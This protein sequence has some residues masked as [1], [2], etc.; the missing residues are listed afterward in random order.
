[1]T[2]K[3]EEEEG[4]LQTQECDWQ[5]VDSQLDTVWGNMQP[6]LSFNKMQLVHCPVN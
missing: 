4:A 3:T 6:L 2:V 5:T 1:M